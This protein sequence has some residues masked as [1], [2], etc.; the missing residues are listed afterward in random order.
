MGVSAFAAQQPLGA[1][2]A[3]PGVP[4]K[5]VIVRC[6]MCKHWCKAKGVFLL[7]FAQQRRELR[8]RGGKDFPS[9]QTWD[10]PKQTWYPV[11]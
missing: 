5:Q 6:R 7:F 4:E 2:I 3:Q 11:C 10:V 9:S 1:R 8:L